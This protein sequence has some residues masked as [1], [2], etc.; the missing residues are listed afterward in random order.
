MKDSKLILVTGATGYVGGRLVPKLLEAGHRVRCLVRDPSRLQ[1]RAW[2]NQ[3]EIVTGD[4]LSADD[5]TRAM[6]GASVAYYLIHGMQGGKINAERDLQVARN[7][8]QAAED[9][10]IQN[11]I[12]LGELVDPAADLSPYL[13]ARH[14]TGYL[15]RYGKVPVTEFRAGMIIGSGSALFEMVRYLTEREPLLVC[16]AWFYSEAQPIAIRDV[17]SY[18]V[19]ALKTPESTGRV[20]EIGGPSRLTYADMLL[21]YARE[22][23]LKRRLVRTPIYAPRLS[24]YWVHMITPIH[25]R[26]VAP[27]IEGL[28]A[29]LI[30]RD[31]AARKLFPNIQPIDFQ[32]AA[33]LAL[34][35]IQRDNVETNWANALVTVLGDHKP[36]QFSVEEG[37]FIERRKTLLDVSPEAVFRAYTGIGGERGWLYMNWA[38]GLRGWMD[39]VIGGVGLRRGRRHPDEVHAGEALDFWRVEVVEKNTKMR[40]LAEMIVPGK[41]WLEFES[42]LQGDKTLLTVTAYFDPHGLS[43]FLYWYA[44]WPFHKFIFDGLARRLASRARVLAHSY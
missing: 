16:P 34:G 7:F 18:L 35:R 14:E 6:K 10:G 23:G 39:K 19:D 43:G 31:D 44:M 1:G 11:I 30:V 36:Y 33:H 25:W 12:Y 20:I 27:L 9:A 42:Q 4:A 15:L 13:R 21:G 2:L 40:L 3:V 22:R 41:A 5:L 32:T 28:R 37:M 38:W 26:V 17:L 29:N 24:A 8:A